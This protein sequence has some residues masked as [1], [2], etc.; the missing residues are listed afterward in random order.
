MSDGTIEN[1]PDYNNWFEKSGEENPFIMKPGEVFC[2]K[3]KNP[4]D[5][6]IASYCQAICC[7]HLAPRK[8]LEFKPDD[9]YHRFERR[10]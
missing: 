10:K 6:K 2:Q 4:D 9:S 7:P 1:D 3:R 8:Q 5:E